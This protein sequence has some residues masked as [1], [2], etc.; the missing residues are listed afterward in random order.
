V[1]TILVA[2]DESS[3]LR[4]YQRLLASPQTRVLMASDGREA[5]RLAQ[6][7]RPDMA[8]LDVSMPQLSGT[9]VCR[10]LR[11]DER[12]RRMGI[13]ILTGTGGDPAVEAELLEAG[14]DDYL[15]KPF[16]FREFRARVEAVLRRC[17]TRP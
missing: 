11:G 13:I 2:D 6:E 15:P 16:D 7:E 8:I 5:L 3:I 4:I 14:A 1:T 12:T 17:R 9:Q 10:A